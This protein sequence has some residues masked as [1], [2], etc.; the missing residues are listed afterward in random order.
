LQKSNAF[1]FAMPRTSLSDIAEA[2]GYAKSTV[3][4]ALRDHPSVK[5]AT[6]EMIRAAGKTG[7]RHWFLQF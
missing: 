2:T 1:K 3:S 4:M 7:V 5:P 6:R